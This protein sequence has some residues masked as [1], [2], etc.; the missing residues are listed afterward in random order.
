MLGAETKNAGQAGVFT[1]GIQLLQDVPQGTEEALV[2]FGKAFVFIFFHAEGLDDPRPGDRFVQQRRQRPHG[3][4]GP[5][6]HAA[7]L[8]AELGDE[9]YEKYESELISYLEKNNTETREYQQLK[10]VEAYRELIEELK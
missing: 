5:G 6:G 8:L 7:H 2:F 1:K 10:W 3:D 4:L 9:N